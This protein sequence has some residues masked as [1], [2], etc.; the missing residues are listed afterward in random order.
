MRFGS[1]YHLDAKTRIRENKTINSAFILVI[2]AQ[3]R[4]LENVVRSWK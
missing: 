3:F 1:L 2:K 4:V